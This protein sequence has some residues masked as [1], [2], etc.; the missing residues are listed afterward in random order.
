MTAV[1]KNAG[2]ALARIDLAETLADLY[3]VV[4]Q[5][6]AASA[7][8]S[9]NLTDKERGEIAEKVRSK[10]KS[11]EAYNEAQIARLGDEE[12]L[13]ERIRQLDH[14]AITV[15]FLVKYDGI[16]AWIR[17]DYLSMRNIDPNP[18]V[19]A[20]LERVAEVKAEAKQKGH[21]FSG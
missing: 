3:L 14:T 1:I 13:L 6:D 7:L 18:G 2:L 20:F 17:D 9:L 5:V 15:D 8:G 16:M 11:M 19:V 10:V 4:E 21:V 12:A